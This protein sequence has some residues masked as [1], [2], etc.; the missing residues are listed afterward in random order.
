MAGARWFERGEDYFAEGRVR[1]LTEREGTI[2][3][4]VRGTKPYHVTLRAQPGDLEYSCTCPLGRDGAFCKHC[5]AVGLAWLE[6][7]EPQPKKS[8]R[9]SQSA[10]TADDIRAY[11]SRQDQSVLVDL[12]MER[13]M[14]D[15]VLWRRLALQ[16][17]KKGPEGLDLRAYR[18]ALVHA[19]RPGGFVA[20]DDMYQYARGIDEAIDSIEQ[21]LEEGHTAEVIGLAEHALAA[22]EDAMGTVDDSDGYMGGILGRLQETHLR[23]CKKAKPE[24]AALARRLLEWELATDWDTF[25]DAAETYAGVLGEK[26]LAAYRKLAEAEWARVPAVGPGHDDPEKYGKRFRITHIMETLAR[27]TGD[28]E[29]VVT[30]KQRDLSSA[31]SYLDIAETYQQ[32]GK[33]DL[34]LEWAERG[35]QAFPERTDSRLR[36]FLAEEY[37]RRK[38]HDEAMALAWAEFTDSPGLEQYRNLKA[39]ADRAGGWPSWREKAL[40][41]LREA[42]AQARRRPPRNQWAWHGVADYSVLVSIFLWEKDLEAA[43]REAQE[44]GCSNRLWL[45]LAA[46]RK[47]E[48]PEDALAVYQAQ[49]EPTLGQKNNEAYGAAVGLLREIRA[50]MILL[51]R[52]ADFAPYLASVRSA[53]KPKRNFLKL[54]D[55]A[56]WD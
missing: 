11:L 39:H 12:L 44:G 13:A 29:A 28:V 14:D 10:L 42:I 27:Q 3:A 21:L 47:Q 48:H 46:K 55:R 23:A 7:A 31:Y 36:E 40:A 1:G 56:R 9:K 37:H 53:H 2:A 33:H 19:I 34:A 30:V 6:S 8:R 35:V 20:Y 52:K 50:L 18:E 43:W 24:P 17:A 25:F 15:D 5:V 16:M 49:V 38:R 45:E 22:V 51:G 32:A 41:H 26:G 54:L 4:K